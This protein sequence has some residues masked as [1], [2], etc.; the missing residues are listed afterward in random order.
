MEPKQYQEDGEIDLFDI[1]K[2]FR[3]Y[4]WIFAITVFTATLISG[5]YSYKF[6][7]NVYESNT[8]LYIG[9]LSQSS[10][11]SLLQDLQIGTNVIKDYSEIVKSR[12]V[13]KETKKQL[14]ED[15]KNNSVLSE[16]SRLPYDQISDMVTV[17]LI[18]DTKIM[19]IAVKDKSPEVCAL[20]ADKVAAIFIDKVK[21]ITKIDNVEIIDT[22]EM[23]DIPVLP[24]RKKN[25][26]ISFFLGILAGAGVIILIEF[27][28]NT[29]KSAEDVKK[30]LPLP[31]MG[32]I[33][34]IK[35]DKTK[36]T[37]NIGIVVTSKPKSASAESYRIIRSNIQFSSVDTDIKCILITGAGQCEGKTVTSCNL[38]AVFASAGSMVMLIDGDLRKPNIHNAFEIPNKAG[39]TNVL[40]SGKD[41]KQVLTKTQIENLDILTSGPIPPNPSEIIGSTA[42]RNMIERIR[43]DYDMIIIDSPPAGFI[44]DAQILSTMT[45]GTLLV[46]SAGKSKI[47]TI[48]NSI[49]IL[50]NVNANILGIVLNRVKGNIR[51]YY[52]D[53]TSVVKQK[54][55]KKK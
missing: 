22:A 54:P 49:D 2:A 39:I 1:L 43:S 34:E 52:Y 53:E 37:D 25:L 44:T 15:A 17:S 24:N 20:I 18:S 19:R 14:E 7:E 9:K 4:W 23:N 8:S 40:T 55:S 48:E 27:F 47:N 51:N 5:I 30:K 42:M 29:L 33:N 6:L 32:T 21:K 50:R 3:R 38:A 26:M 45:D 35:R 41:Y 10:V 31:L 16:V 11:T 12:T 28:D 13:M 46:V 36:V